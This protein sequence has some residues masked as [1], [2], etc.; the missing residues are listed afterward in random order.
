FRVPTPA[1]YEAKQIQKR[2]E[3]KALKLERDELE[4][5]VNERT[6]RL[7]KLNA[8]LHHRLRNLLSVVSALAR[9]SGA[10]QRFSEVFDKRLRGLA[11]TLELLTDTQW[12]GARIRDVLKAQLGVFESGLNVR[13]TTGP[14]FMLRPAAVQPLGMARHELATN[15]LKH[16]PGG[17][18]SVSWEVLADKEEARLRFIWAETRSPKGAQAS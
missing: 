13:V 2:G 3:M 16:N 9:Q 14:Y 17:N 5:R 15:A 8:E 7:N 18:H 10:D 11:A 4:L 12:E 1:E 6:E